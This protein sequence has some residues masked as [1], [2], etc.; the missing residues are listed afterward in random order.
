MA[1]PQPCAPRLFREALTLIELLVVI[2]IL[3][4]LMALL[5]PA[6]QGCGPE[7]SAWSVPTT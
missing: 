6:V 7:P 1:R 2:A 3:A 4:I 5:V